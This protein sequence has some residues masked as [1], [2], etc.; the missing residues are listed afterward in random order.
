MVRPEKLDKLLAAKP[1]TRRWYQDNI[2]ITEDK[3]IGPFNFKQIGM[4]PHR[5]AERHWNALVK[6]A[7]HNNINVTDDNKVTPL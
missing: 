2:N 1:T 7:L 6:E 4:S 5:I 3:I